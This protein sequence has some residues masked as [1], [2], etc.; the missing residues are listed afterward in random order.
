MSYQERIYRQ[1]GFC[2]EKNNTA[3][4]AKFSSDIYIFN[5][6][7]FTMD[8]ADKINCKDLTCDISGVSYNNIFTATTNCFTSNHL[9]GSCFNSI[10]WY[11]KVYEND[12]LVYS[13]SF[14]TS[15]GITGNIPTHADFSGSVVTA[16]DTLGYD[17]SFSGTAYTIAKPT[18]E[19]KLAIS[20]ILNIDANCPL[21]AFTSGYTISC[22]AGYTV[23]PANDSCIKVTT[24]GATLNGTPL[25]ATTATANTGYAFQTRFYETVDMT[26]LPIGDNGN[27]PPLN[28]NN[29]TGTTLSF[30]ININPTTNTLW[31]KSFPN[32]LTDGRLN[33]TG[34]YIPGGATV[35]FTHCL[36]IPTS[37]LYT[38][39]I[40]GNNFVN[41]KINGEL[42]VNINQWDTNFYYWH[43]FPIQLTSGLNIIELIG[44]DDATSGTFG[45]FGAE[46]YSATTSQLSGMTSTTQL[47]PYIVFSTKDKIGDILDI[48][49]VSGYTC[50]TGYALNA[51]DNTYTCSKIER[52]TPTF[53]DGFSGSCVTNVDACD[54]IFSGLTSGST[55]VYLIDTQTGVTL[56]F[57]FTANTSS[58][59]DDNQAKFKFEVYKY[60]SNSKGFL[61]PA[62]YTSPFISWNT[63]SST[64][65][66]TAVVPVNNLNLDG[67]YLIKGYYLHNIATEFALKLNKT[68]DTSL[69]RVGESYGIYEPTR[70]FYFVAINAAQ[71]PIIE[72]GGLQLPGIKALVVTSF[73]LTDGQTTALIPNSV[74][75]YVVALNG[76]TLAEGDEYDFTITGVTIGNDIITTIQLNAP[77]VAGDMLTLA[78][79]NADYGDTFRVDTID[80]QSSITSGTTGNQGTNEVYYNTTTGKYEIYTSL[81][82]LSNNDV[83]VTLNGV[84]LANNIDYYLSLSDKNRIILEGDLI[85]SDIINI[86]YNTGIL[87]QGNITDVNP[88]IAWSIETAPNDTNGTFTVELATDEAFTNIINTASIDYIIDV[89]SY[90]TNIGLIGDYGTDLYYRV[91]NEKIYKTICNDSI[92]SIA[93]SEIVPITIGTNATNNY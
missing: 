56:D 7:I 40:C 20:A 45:A 21:T 36:D 70:D 79:V 81:E 18:E 14:Y 64:S 39:G 25:T 3:Q 63:F 91:K 2:V 19:V 71:T 51:C 60:N 75:N 90:N 74:G 59:Y 13:A 47:N 26:K 43:V 61:T 54:L 78:Y 6:P 67:D 24:T 57:I 50:P 8:G 93:Y 87:V 27:T 85:V 62:L 41:I 69:N 31:G 10:D 42:I 89:T 23:T 52:A 82:V 5:T 77:A 49:P 84:T 46:I 48:G 15:T 80:I 17:Y 92:D 86:Y 73:E 58:F 65:A 37:G 34:I 55:N 9:S 12:E 33:N 38:L 83:G 35:G 30:V 16:F 53:P 28:Y 66:T 1:A 44:I 88:N 11:T 4:I 72:L 32:G 68:F 29:G 76:I 22:P